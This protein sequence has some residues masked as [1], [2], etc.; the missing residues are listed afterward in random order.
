DSW[1]LPERLKN[2][3]DRVRKSQKLIQLYK[4]PFLNEISYF[5]KM[6]LTTR[7]GTLKRLLL[8]IKEEKNISGKKWLLE[9]IEERIEKG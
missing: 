9:K 5:R 3:H 4:R 1:N 7:S 2:L 6:L 8:E